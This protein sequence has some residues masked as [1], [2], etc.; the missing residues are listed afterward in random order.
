MPLVSY[1]AAIRN[2]KNFRNFIYGFKQAHVGLATD[3]GRARN[4]SFC[5]DNIYC[6]LCVLKHLVVFYC[7]TIHIMLVDS[8]AVM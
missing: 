6:H 8:R 1:P 3:T 5:I 7:Y 2:L 4:S